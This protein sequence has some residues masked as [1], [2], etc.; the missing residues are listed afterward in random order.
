MDGNDVRMEK[1]LS[2]HK[3]VQFGSIIT[4]YTFQVQL[5]WKFGLLFT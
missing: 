4:I 5:L 1:K 2:Y 3:N